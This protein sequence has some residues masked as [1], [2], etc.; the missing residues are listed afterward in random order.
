[1]SCLTS[2]WIELKKERLKFNVFRFNVF[3]ELLFAEQSELIILMAR[4]I[5]SSAM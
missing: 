3:D 5:H 4:F 1:M 2:G